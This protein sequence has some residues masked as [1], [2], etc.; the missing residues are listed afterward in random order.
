[1]GWLNRLIGTIGGAQPTDWTLVDNVPDPGLGIAGTPIAPDACYIEVYVESLRL[2]KAR[3]FATTFHGLIYSFAALAREGTDRA[4]LASVT[5][6]QN[7]A[8]LG[9]NDLGR[10]ITVSKRIMGAMPWR[11]NPLGLELGLFSVKSGNLLTPLVNY[12]T[13]VSDQAGISI[14]TRLNPFVPL[15][16]EG[17]DM[18]TGQKDSSEIELAIDTDLTLA[19]SRFCAL[20]GRPKGTLDAAGLTID[21]QDRKLLL[22]GKPL[23][24]A[25][26]VFSIRSSAFN[27]GWGEITAL[28]ES[29][30]DFM[31][32]IVS[33]KRREAE[34]ALAAFNRQVIVSPD[35]ISGDK[36]RLRERAGADLR[37]AF[38]GGGQSAP[39]AVQNRF[40]NRQ[41]SDLNLYD[42]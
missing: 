1:M 5:K 30:A 36:S 4:E 17:L 40:A 38:P 23:Q 22:D 35:L 33:G 28:K 16:M 9:G 8:A 39:A 27:P 24:A 32:A 11:G 13:K 12:V 34:E 18:I 20:I 2:E 37:E 19:E 15:V 3:R 25:H 29:Y 31:R 14:L 10:V 41:L 7:L 6:P 21:P 42:T 26:C